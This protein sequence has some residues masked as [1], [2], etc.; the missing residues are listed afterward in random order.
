VLLGGNVF[1]RN[2]SSYE[3]KPEKWPSTSHD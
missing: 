1:Q 2:A 3:N